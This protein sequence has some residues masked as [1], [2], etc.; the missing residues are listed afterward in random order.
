MFQSRS[1][2]TLCMDDGGGLAPGAS[3]TWWWFCDGGN[4]NQR[5]DL[6]GTGEPA[7]VRRGWPTSATERGPRRLFVRPAVLRS[8]RPPHWPPP[9]PARTQ[10]P[11]A[12]PRSPAPRPPLLVAAG[13]LCI[14]AK[15]N[16]CLDGA[17]SFAGSGAAATIRTCDAGSPHQAWRLQQLPN[18]AVQIVNA[19][20]GFC[21]DS[22]SVA[23]RSQFAYAPC[24][25]N[26]ANQQFVVGRP[27]GRKASAADAA[28][29]ATWLAQ[30]HGASPAAGPAAAGEEPAPVTPVTPAAAAAPVPADAADPANA[31]APTVADDAAAPA[32][33][34][35]M[36][37]PAAS[38]EAPPATAEAA[39][40]SPVPL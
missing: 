23:W 35:N 21:L 15:N 14:P 10:T 31:A 33:A 27:A 26:A 30:G 8:H 40:N 17:N 28:A 1:N 37:A 19:K 36:T 7:R 34:T 13:Q 11:H 2:P 6:I 24:D 16:L 4:A 25:A 9:A 12:R 22:S 32:G 3:S 39:A 29:A 5:F 18:G 38:V 20:L